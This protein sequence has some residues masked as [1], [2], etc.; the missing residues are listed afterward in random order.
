M[1]SGKCQMGMTAL[2]IVALD[3]S[4]VTEGLPVPVNNYITRPY[5]LIIQLL[6]NTT[7]YIQLPIFGI[8]GGPCFELIKALCQREM[9]SLFA[10]EG[11]NFSLKR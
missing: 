9:T 1:S 6:S 7:V 11:L 4:K 3:L 2:S 8:R 5:D 10:D